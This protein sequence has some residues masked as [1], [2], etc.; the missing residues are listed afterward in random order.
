MSWQL[1]HRDGAVLPFQ[2]PANAS[3]VPIPVTLSLGKRVRENPAEIVFL[4][5]DCMRLRV[6]R[7]LVLDDDGWTSKGGEMM[8]FAGIRVWERDEKYKCR[9]L[10]NIASRKRI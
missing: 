9:N 5:S 10:D 7:G 8:E 4:G 1:K 3:L 6:R 2:L